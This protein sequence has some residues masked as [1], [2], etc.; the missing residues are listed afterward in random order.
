[1]ALSRQQISYFLLAIV[2][3][4]LLSWAMQSTLLLNWDVSWNLHAAQRLLAGGSYQ[5]DF[6][7]I[8][9]PMIF[10]LNIP[11]VLLARFL[12]IDTILA[13]RIYVFLLATLSLVLCCGLI[14]EIFSAQSRAVAQQFFLALILAFL[15]L[16]VYEFGQREHLMIILIMPYLLAVVYQLQGNKL[17]FWIAVVIGLLA[18]L[19]F[20]I[21]PFFLAVL[22]I[23]EMYY[24]YS[25]R[26][27]VAWI[28]METLMIIALLVS[29]L[30]A[31][32]LFHADYINYIIPL[33]MRFYYSGVGFP[34][35]ELVLHP[36]AIF[37]YFVMAVYFFQYQRG[38]SKILGTLLLLVLSCFLLSYF[39]QRTTWYYHIVPAF[40]LAILLWVL[41]ISSL[42][43]KLRLTRVEMVFMLLAASLAF[44]FPIFYV[45][46][47]YF[48]SVIYKNKMGKLITF[49][50]THARHKPIYFF[51]TSPSF[52]F[53]AVDYANAIPV[54][55]FAS[56][57]WVAGVLKHPTYADG[58][59]LQQ[60]R[61]YFIETIAGELN[62]ARP[63]WVFV[64]VQQD[65]PYLENIEFDYIR[66]FSRSNHFQQAWKLY[67]YFSTI[68]EYPF[69]KF[70]VYQRVV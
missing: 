19:G 54:S 55:R 16:P 59:L 36:V 30:C 44:F 32:A 49:M 9:P 41:I 7:D 34:W 47:M 48:S 60:D 50:Q 40:S 11:P 64:D 43:S 24:I 8:N 62:A 57:I 17:N 46:T 23:V 13:M 27:I 22:V 63:T 5:H 1:M 14:Y 66:Y 42:A 2:G 52:E 26:N 10:Y 53:P 33:A 12:A 39:V 61:D 31:I 6:S 25:V 51:S 56:A 20:A 29:Y 67:A 58:G 69:Y 4:Y 70:H 65:K 68:E 3:I 45:G 35:R 18:G 38:S 21:K 28:R 15:M 37:C